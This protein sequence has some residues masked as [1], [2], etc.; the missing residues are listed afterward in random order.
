MKKRVLAFLVVIAML[1]AL[2]PTAT[3]AGNDHEIKVFEGNINFWNEKT[4]KIDVQTKDSDVQGGDVLDNRTSGRFGLSSLWADGTW[5]FTAVPREGYYFYRWQ[6]IGGQG[7][8]DGVSG[9]SENNPISISYDDQSNNCNA[10]AIFKKTVAVAYT[11]DIVKGG[12]GDGTVTK[13]PDQASYAS[14]TVVALSATPDSNSTFRGFYTNRSGKTYSGKLDPEQVTMDSNKTIYAVFDEKVT[15]ELDINMEGDGSGTVTKTPNQSS[16]DAGTVVTLSATPDSDSTFR[17]FYTNRTG[18]SNNRTYSGKLDP[19]QVTMDSNK[20]VYAVFDRKVT[21]SLN[22]QMEGDGSGTVTKTPNQSSYDVGTVVTLS[23][24]PDSNS[25]FR[26]FYLTRTWHGWPTYDYEYSNK[27]DPEEVTMNSNITVYAVFDEVYMYDHIDVEIE[28]SLTIDQQTDGVSNP[29]YPKTVNVTVSHPSASYVVGGVTYYLNESDFSVTSTEFRALNLSFPWPDSVTVNATLTD[30]DHNVYN[31]SQ[32]FGQAGIQAAWDLCP[33]TEAAG[34]KGFDFVV[35]A[36]DIENQITNTVTF[37]T[38]TGGT[39]D[40]GTADIVHTG[41][42]DGSSVPTPPAT[43]ADSGYHLLGWTKNGGSTYYTS[44]QVDAMTVDANVTFTAVYE[45]NSTYNVTYDG[46][47]NNGGTVPTDTEDYEAGETVTVKTDSPTMTGYTFVGWEA[48]FAAPGDPNYVGDDTF[49]M[50]S[51]DVT[52]TAQWDKDYTLTVTENLLGAGASQYSV[53]GGSRLGPF[54]H[55]YVVTESS[56]GVKL[57]LGDTVRIYMYAFP[58]YD[59]INETDFYVDVTITELD[60]EYELQYKEVPDMVFGTFVFPV[61]C[62]N[63]H[64]IREDLAYYGDVLRGGIDVDGDVFDI[65]DVDSDGYVSIPLITYVYDGDSNIGGNQMR[66]LAIAVYEDGTYIGFVKMSGDDA[67]KIFNTNPK[68]NNEF[69]YTQT[70]SSLNTTAKFLYTGSNTD[71]SFLVVDTASMGS[72]FGGS[73]GSVTVYEPDSCEV[74]GDWDVTYEEH[75]GSLVVDQDNVPYNTLV[76]DPG[77]SS[78]TGYTFNGWF[79]AEVGGTKW[80]FEND[81]MP[82]HDL[83]LHAQWTLNDWDVTYEA[84]GGAAVTDQD[85]VPY[86]TLVTDPGDSSMTGY[87]FNGWFTDE[88]GGTKWDF[89]NDTMPDNDLTL[90]AQWSAITYTVTYNIN[91]GDAG[92]TADSVH[93]YDVYKTLTKNGYTKVGY[94]FMGWATNSGELV[95]NTDGVLNLNAIGGVVYVD[96]ESVVN[97]SVIDGD[98]VELFA[99]W[100]PTVYNITYNLDGGTNDPTNPVTYTVESPLITLA[101]PTKENYDFLGWTPSDNIPAGST[102]DKVFTAT[103]TPTVYNITYVM[104]NGT[105]DPANPATYTVESPLITLA[106]PTRAGYTFLGW[107][108]SDNIPAGSTGDKEF[109]ATWSDPIVYN[110]TYVMNGG[111]N[112]PANPATYTVESPLITLAAPTRT[113]YTF[114]GWTPSDNIPA[115]STGDKV[116]TATWSDPIVYNITYV[117]NGGTNNPANPA[118]YTVESPLITLAA[119]ARA[120]YGFTGWTPAGTIPA[121][122]TGDLTF[123]AG[124]A[125]NTYTVTFIDFD[126]TVL[127]TDTVGYGGD[128]D[129]PADPEREGYNFTGWDTDFT[130]VTAD[131]TVQALY[132]QIT[133]TVTFIDFDGT[134]LGAETVAYGGDATAPADPEREGYG[135][136]GWDTDFTNVTGDLTVQALYQINVYTVTFVDHDGTVIDEQQ[137]EWGSDATAPT[138]PAWD[139]HTFTGWDT[140]FTNVTSDLTVTAQYTETIPEEEGPA[141]GPNNNWL[142]WLLLIPGIGLIIL[143]LAFWLRIVPIVEKVTKN[144]DGTMSIQWGYENRKGRKIEF[145]DEN[146]SVLSALAGSI[147]SSTLVSPAD[148]DMTVPP[149]KFEKGR[150]ENVF[151]TVASADA[152]VEWKIRSRKATADITK[153]DK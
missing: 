102:G 77:D 19:A 116:F 52:L 143:L 41:V 122:S 83:K 63:G 150:V 5:T 40:G 1:V 94:T 136:T 7:W 35:E 45:E 81:T 149:V 22:V 152:K 79:T 21:Y 100:E 137:I 17:G 104:N 138:D 74:S 84:H 61:Y 111:T 109:T 144:P 89:D 9:T 50:P 55:D 59:Y 2:M 37:S 71:L 132:E 120:N 103:W 18:P 8:N 10:I 24:T 145:D 56:S 67:G 60:Q 99:V 58:G 27:L 4:V 119:P 39:I 13:T 105:N 3:F 11:L 70:T 73:N 93:T 47:G 49:L 95:A 151:V 128:A 48:S 107:T 62:A 112:D 72:S 30:G 78:M 130:N 64:L 90:H 36:E 91:T 134:V 146:D 147:I 118:T 20:T 92:T 108:P 127:G 106:A 113:G 101:A 82:D 86:G 140:P 125:L 87:T 75:G 80:D 29:G 23:A 51:D 85:N 12:N 88:T 121:G 53:N 110:I 28:G 115:G 141:A 42:L 117:M 97:L 34:N 139:E 31:I 6:G 96:E 46:N 135:F 98:I 142:W 126:G 14:E 57:K 69:R 68:N 133:F 32:T 66:Q 114:L 44:T 16:Y 153:E 148:G 26:G 123:T 43:S 38:T 124:W 54:K 129:A 15:Y 25:T 131:L 76:T 65:S 33:G